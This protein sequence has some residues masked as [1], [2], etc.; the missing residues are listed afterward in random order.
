MPRKDDYSTSIDAAFNLFMDTIANAFGGIV[1][2]AMAVCILIQLS[3][4]ESMDRETKSKQSLEISLQRLQHENQ[5]IQELCT[6]LNLE[7][8]DESAADPTTSEKARALMLRQEEANEAKAR[9]TAKLAVI[10]KELIELQKKTSGQ[11]KASAFATQYLKLK[12]EFDDL[13]KERYRKT[14]STAVSTSKEQVPIL[15]TGGKMV[16]L[17][18]YDEKTGRSNGLN[19]REVE[20]VINE[21]GKRYFKPKAGRGVKVED[22]PEFKAKLTEMFSK[23]NPTKKYL[24]FCVWPDSYKEYSILRQK[25]VDA[26]LGFYLVLMQKDAAVSAAG[27]AEEMGSGGAAAN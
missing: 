5:N 10:E 24:G 6:A 17:L 22:T 12:H 3:G 20:E 16:M 18:S 15:I 2:I 13:V 14:S 21:K 26:K 1:L 7:L 11:S 8:N 9:D 23:F 19:T 4:D 25:A 27:P